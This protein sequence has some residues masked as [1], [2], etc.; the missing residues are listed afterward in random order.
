MCGMSLEPW[1]ND[2]CNDGHGGG[3]DEQANANVAS[4]G[5]FNLRAFGNGDL[6]SYHCAST[7]KSREN[8]KSDNNE[9]NHKYLSKPAF[10]QL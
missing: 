4:G 10:N 7:S 9:L 3:E 5:S 1:Q 8:C 2:E 6:A